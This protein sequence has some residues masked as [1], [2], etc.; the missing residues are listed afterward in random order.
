MRTF[1]L[2]LAVLSVAC[3]QPAAAL[4][5]PEA[6][7]ADPKGEV[8][9]ITFAPGDK[10]IRYSFDTENEK[11]Q[12]GVFARYGVKSI[13]V[14]RFTP[15]EAGSGYSV[16]WRNVGYSIEAPAPL[17]LMLESTYK[18]LA[19]VPLI[20]KTGPDGVPAEAQ[21]LSAMRAAIATAY[22]ALRSSI[23][24]PEYFI[25]SGNAKPGKADI[26]A[27]GKLFDGAMAPFLNV[28]DGVLT[29]QLLETPN[30]MFGVGG[31]KLV[32]RQPI[33]VSGEIN[34]PWGTPIKVTGTVEATYFDRPKNHLTVVTRTNLDPDDLKASVEQY[35]EALKDKLPA[36]AAEKAKEQMD[37]FLKLSITERAELVLDVTTG[38]PERLSYEKSSQIN[39]E[40]QIERRMLRRQ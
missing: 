31:A 6:F 36:D 20:Y 27:F 25:E 10:P 24:K 12:R 13:D 21:D 19:A 2:F 30:M 3:A 9:T 29:Q 34:A 22:K 15:A 39:G 26:E 32:L 7:P 40:T 8:V 33:A 1:R 38:L 11:S 18:V 23:V 4:P 14:L 5:R 16:E 35:F 37:Q 17:N 28:E